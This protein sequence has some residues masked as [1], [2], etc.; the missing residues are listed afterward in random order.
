MMIKINPKA[1]NKNLFK[2]CPRCLTFKRKCYC[3]NGRGSNGKRGK[4]TQYVICVQ[5]HL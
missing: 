3:M 5:A 1:N 2:P 4:K